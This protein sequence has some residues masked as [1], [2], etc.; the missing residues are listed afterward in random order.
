MPT[1]PL[2]GW[3]SSAVTGEGRRASCGR[4]TRLC[5]I[6]NEHRDSAVA[7]ATLVLRPARIDAQ[8]FVPNPAPPVARGF[9]GEKRRDWPS[10]ATEP[11]GLAR[12]L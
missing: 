2:P 12:R 3:P 4:A 6:E 1:A 9:D 7:G 10:T 8:A 5:R 11:S